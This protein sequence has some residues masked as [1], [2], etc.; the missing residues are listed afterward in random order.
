MIALEPITVAGE[1]MHR[2]AWTRVRELRGSPAGPWGVY[3]R[4]GNGA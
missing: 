1:V 4:R 3:Q 2:L